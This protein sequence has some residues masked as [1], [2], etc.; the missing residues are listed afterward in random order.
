VLLA[1][2][3]LEKMKKPEGKGLTFEIVA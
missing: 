3:D 2:I 1:E